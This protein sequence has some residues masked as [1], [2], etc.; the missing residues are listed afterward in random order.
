VDTDIYQNDKGQLL[1]SLVKG[2][3]HCSY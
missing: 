3:R 1:P 2:E